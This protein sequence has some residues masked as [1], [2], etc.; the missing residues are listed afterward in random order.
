MAAS[1]DT[2]STEPEQEPTREPSDSDN[3]DQAADGVYLA[4]DANRCIGAGQ[5]EMLAP[6]HFRVDDDSALAEFVGQDSLPLTEAELLI[7][8]C[9]SGALGIRSEIVDVNQD[10]DPD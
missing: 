6:E 3:P 1:P 10:G 7:D 9:P 2:D 4:V 5:C 8:R